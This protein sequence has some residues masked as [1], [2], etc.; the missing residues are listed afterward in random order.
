MNVC[1]AFPALAVLIS[2]TAVSCREEV[3]NY[4]I[5]DS[6]VPV[7]AT[8]SALTRA[9]SE[10]ISCKEAF[11]GE[12]NGFNVEV[13]L[14]VGD[15]FLTPALAGVTRGTIATTEGVNGVNRIG[16]IF[17]MHAYLS[18]VIATS[19]SKDVD[20]ADKT[21]FHFIGGSV[22]GE[23]V[24]YTGNNTSHSWDWDAAVQ[25][26]GSAED[27]DAARPKWRANLTSRFWSY[28]PVSYIDGIGIVW[29]H[30][31]SGNEVPSDSQQD[32]VYFHYVL[33]TPASAAPYKDAEN[34]KDILFAYN[35]QEFKDINTTSDKLDI[36]F[37]H[38]LAAVNFDITTMEPNAEFGAK[39]ITIKH[40]RYSGD[41]TIY[42]PTLDAPTD[43]DGTAGVVWSNLSTDFRSFSQTFD[44]SADFENIGTTADPMIRQKATGSKTFFMI[45]QT[46]SDAVLSVAFEFK[47]G[48]VPITIDV[49]LNADVW[50][51]GKIYTYR[52]NISGGDYTLLDDI[53]NQK[54]W[55]DGSTD[56]SF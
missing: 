30:K 14:S 1:K 51:A 43:D 52:I 18:D 13:N 16:Q 22:A 2:I 46:L 15:N 49:P 34:Q 40:V 17:G 11:S 50:Q 10:S 25:T 32:Q 26:A 41:C 29:P 38:A 55:V 21:D 7:V 12:I 8:Q 37:Y 5:G 45:P 35:A 6:I 36:H 19:T 48:G 23:T 31:A 47:N 3:L 42:G 9:L 24:D 54:K 39:S 4:S 56:T 33:P 27:K 44:K 28:Y 20:P 53:L